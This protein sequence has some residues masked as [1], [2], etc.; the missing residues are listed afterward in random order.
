M[1]ESKENS[2]LLKGKVTRYTTV[3]TNEKLGSI[4][5][6]GTNTKIISSEKRSACPWAGKR[7]LGTPRNQAKAIRFSKLYSCQKH[8]R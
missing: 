7:C 3:S 5:C 4:G 8:Y 2:H 6:Y 1:G